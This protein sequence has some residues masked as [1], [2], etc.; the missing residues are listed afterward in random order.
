[1]T[2]VWQT[3]PALSRPLVSLASVH[4]RLVDELAELRAQWVRARGQ[5]LGEE[6]GGDLLGR[7]DPERGA[8]RATPGELADAG[9]DLVHH[10]V[11]DHREA[12]PEADALERRLGEQRP[13]ERLEV[14]AARQVVSAHVADRAGAQ[15]AG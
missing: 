2:Y 1:M 6:Q 14:G 13:P 5:E 9:R 12:E 15:Q 4:Q 3:R 8:G 7:V 11:M 10:R